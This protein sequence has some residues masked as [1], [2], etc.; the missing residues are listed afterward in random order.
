MRALILVELMFSILI[1][2]TIGL[3][4]TVVSNAFV[5]EKGHRCRGGAHSVKKLE[6]RP[7]CFLTS[8]KL[9]RALWM[10]SELKLLRIP[11][12]RNRK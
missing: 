1:G 6:Q 3:I 10:F 9:R 12:R 4:M 8:L 2:V 11:A 7:L 5:L